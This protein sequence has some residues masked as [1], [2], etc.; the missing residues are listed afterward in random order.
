MLKPKPEGHTGEASRWEVVQADSMHALTHTAGVQCGGPARAPPS[1]Q[2]W[3]GSSRCI[4]HG[5]LAGRTHSPGLQTDR[6]VCVGTQAEGADE[7]K[8]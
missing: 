4:W 2:A 6:P 1:G 5:F 8:I 7:K 3:A